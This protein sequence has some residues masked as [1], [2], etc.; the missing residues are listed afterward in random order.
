MYYVA[1]QNMMTDE[2]YASFDKRAIIYSTYFAIDILINF[3]TEH[4]FDS[5]SHEPERELTGIFCL[6]IKGRFFFDLIALLPLKLIFTGLFQDGVL[7][8]LDLVKLIRLYVGFRL[9]DYKSNMK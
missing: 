3:I 1:F 6:Y 5:S 2:E 8:L 9:L 4:H 7:R